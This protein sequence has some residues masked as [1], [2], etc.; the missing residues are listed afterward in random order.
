MQMA[1]RQILETVTGSPTDNPVTQ[2]PEN[3]TK[4]WVETDKGAKVTET[5]TYEKINGSAMNPEKT[6]AAE[7]SEEKNVITE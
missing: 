5:I 2:L 1:V 7:D 6:K 4:E 3:E